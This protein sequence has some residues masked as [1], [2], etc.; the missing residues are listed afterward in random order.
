MNIKL[1]ITPENFCKHLFDIVNTF[2]P[3][4]RKIT[5]AEAHLLSH[6]LLLPSKFEHKRFGSVA[7]KTV[8]ASTGFTV[9]NINNKLGSLLEKGYLY[10]DTDGVLYPRKTLFQSVSQFLKNGTFSFTID[11]TLDATN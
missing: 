2:S 10:R 4:T 6:F 9:L 3:E 8:S 7:K 11:L 1:K 5:T